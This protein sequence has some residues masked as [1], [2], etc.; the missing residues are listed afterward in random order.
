MDTEVKC[1]RGATFLRIQGHLDNEKI[2]KAYHTVVVQCWTND[3]GPP[4]EYKD[5]LE[6]VGAIKEKAYHVETNRPGLCPYGPYN[7]VILEVVQA[8]VLELV[9][10]E[11][12]PR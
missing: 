11:K 7:L 5:S 6:S 9:E 2:M 8:N 1:L 10:H 3:S 12:V 4:S